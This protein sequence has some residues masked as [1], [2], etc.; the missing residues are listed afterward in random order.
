MTF[1]NDLKLHIS[2]LILEIYKASGDFP[3]DEI[4]G[5]TS[6]LRRASVSVMTNYVEGYARFTNPQIKNFLT[7][8]YGSLKE[9]ECLVEISK[10]L[11]Y[12]SEEESTY[13]NNQIGTIARM[14]WGTIHKIK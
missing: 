10:K 1:H 8:S 4:Y 7:I 9:T 13:L 11:G 6:Q 3:K 14:L 5:I 12:L 2:D